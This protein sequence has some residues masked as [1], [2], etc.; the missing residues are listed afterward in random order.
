MTA[1]PQ[2]RAH[3]CR[4]A[5]MHIGACTRPGTPSSSFDHAPGFLP[6]HPLTG[7]HV[8]SQCVYAA[9]IRG[10]MHGTPGGTPYRYDISYRYA[11]MP[12]QRTCTSARTATC[13]CPPHP[14]SLPA[15]R[16]RLTGCVCAQQQQGVQEGA[17]C[18]WSAATQTCGFRWGAVFPP[19]AGPSAVAEAANSTSLS[20]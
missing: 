3:A 13:A 19:E 2:S 4:T 9:F 10:A 11:H 1:P 18:Y 16:R 6:R 7:R 5:C 20:G 14:A 12:L 15:A 17:H 8:C